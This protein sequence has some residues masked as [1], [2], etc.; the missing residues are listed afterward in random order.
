M[1][2]VVKEGYRVPFHSLPPL[3]TDPILFSA[4]PNSLREKALTEEIAN[5]VSKGAVELAPHNPGF[6][7]RMFC[8]QKASGAWRPIIDLSNLNKFVTITKF[9]MET[10][11]SVLG[12]IKKDDWMVSIDL[13]DAYLQVPIHPDSR[14]YLRFAS[15]GRVYQF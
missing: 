9:K 4:Y 7:S 3:A 5:L 15:Q 1:T 6:Y 11:Q 10:T 2:E 13:K 12:S 8:V 14:K